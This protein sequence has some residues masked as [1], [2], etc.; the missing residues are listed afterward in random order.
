MEMIFYTPQEVADLL[1]LEVGTVYSYIK[2]GKLPAARIGNRYRI[3]K[4]DVDAF[5]TAATV[6][7]D[8]ARRGSEDLK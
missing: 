4:S 7:P 6:T 5:I 3:R 2:S 1:K 8:P